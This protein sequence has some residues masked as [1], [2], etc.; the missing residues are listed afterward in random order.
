[1]QATVHAYELQKLMQHVPESNNVDHDP[2]TKYAMAA[3]NKRRKLTKAVGVGEEAPPR[4]MKEA[5]NH[6]SRGWEW[7]A[8]ISDEWEGLAQ[9]STTITHSTNAGS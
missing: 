6:P 2:T 4:N 3:S 7:F 8:A 9:L 5:L 1:M